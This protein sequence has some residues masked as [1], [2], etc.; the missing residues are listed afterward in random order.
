M[1]IMITIHYYYSGMA[2]RL[3]QNVR[4]KVHH[5]GDES[6]PQ[7]QVHSDGHL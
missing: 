5:Q 3:V 4:H 2:R 7:L 6:L 1:A